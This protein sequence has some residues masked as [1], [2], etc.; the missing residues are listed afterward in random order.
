MMK[1]FLLTAVFSIATF[2]VSL[3][4]AA[5]NKLYETPP[6]G[7]AFVRVFNYQTDNAI[8]TV[9][10]GKKS[11]AQIAPGNSSDFVFVDAKQASIILDKVDYP[12]ALTE[13]KFFNLVFDGKVVKT[14]EISAL[15][16]KRKGLIHLVNL[17]DQPVDLKTLKGDVDVVPGIASF[18]S[19][20][21]AINPV[22]IAFS[23]YSG[24]QRL[25]ETSEIYLDRG[26]S[27]SLFVFKKNGAASYYWLEDKL[28]ATNK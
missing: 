27:G 2:A 11:V 6:P 4:L 14:V 18:S 26:R 16:D 28:A 23:A 7:S 9:N 13:G 20:E 19:G 10:L 21:R 1:S 17:T 25:L 15:K 5:D 12:V 8:G 24:G 3:T 22:K